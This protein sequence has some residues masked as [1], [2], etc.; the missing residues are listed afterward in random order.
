MIGLLSGKKADGDG[1]QECRLFRNSA[2]RDLPENAEDE[3]EETVTS[4]ELSGAT[5]IKPCMYAN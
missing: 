1:Q 3:D 4:P 5:A 2:C